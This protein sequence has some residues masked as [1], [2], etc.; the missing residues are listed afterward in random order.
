MSRPV[1]LGAKWKHLVLLN[2]RI[3]PQILKPHLPRGTDIDYFNGETFVSVVAFRF[4]QTTIAGWCPAFFHRD[5]EEVNLRFYVTRKEGNEIKRG[6]VFIKE[7]V[8]KP[9]LAWVARKFYAEN[10]VA[11]PMSS[12]IHEGESYRYTWGPDSLEV[13]T[14]SRPLIANESSFERWITEHYWGYT[15]VTESKTT[16]Y[17]VRHPVWNL[18]PVRSHKLTADIPKLYGSEFSSTFEA[19]PVSVFVAD[20]SNV[21]VHW[22]KTIR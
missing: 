1:F 18:Y 2:Y 16:E 7:I 15:K 21:T 12:S 5:F 11:M 9:F 10:Y 8:P 6:V 20:G 17:E 19:A 4:L 13:S 14:E 3:D 22:P